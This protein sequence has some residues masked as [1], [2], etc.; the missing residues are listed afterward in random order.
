M[1]APGMIAGIMDLA[2]RINAA[3][4]SRGLSQ[5]SAIRYRAHRLH[6]ELI[7]HGAS[8]PDEVLRVVTSRVDS[9]VTERG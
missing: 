6:G 8:D 5:D 2:E 3:C 9:E 4:D 1:I 7:A